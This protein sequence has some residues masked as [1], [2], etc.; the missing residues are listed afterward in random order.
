MRILATMLLL[1]NLM[2]GYCQNIIGRLP[3]GLNEVS[4]IA[5]SSQQ[6]AFAYV[7]NDSGDESRFFAI[8]SNAALVTTIRFKGAEQNGKVRDCEDITVGKSDKGDRR[9]IYLGDIGNNFALRPFVCV[10]KIAE[11]DIKLDKPE[12]TVNT[13][14]VF[15]KY[16]DGSRDAET[17][18]VDNQE[19]LLYI[20][21]KREDSVHVYTSKLNW[22]KN[23]TITLEKRSTIFFPGSRPQK[24]IV[25][26]DISW[27]GSKVLLK[28]ISKVYFWQRIEG[29]PVWKTLTRPPVEL[30]YKKEPQGEAICF[31]EKNTGY[32]TV[33]E[34]NNRPVYHYT[35]PQQ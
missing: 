32:Y 21:S 2:P 26:G 11:S 1:A 30:P 16:P 35:I 25:S 3:A 20:V 34:G 9:Y 5:L 24:W 15:F 19:R 4:G 10:Y 31:D 13:I 6:K 12:I 18:M 27:D 7:H 14:P 29:E 28:S 23:D 22:T 8:D 17:I 33:S